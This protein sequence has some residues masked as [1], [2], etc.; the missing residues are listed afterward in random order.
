MR[1]N[2]DKQELIFYYQNED[3]PSEMISKD[4]LIHK[5]WIFNEETEEPLIC[6]GKKI[7]LSP[8]FILE[9]EL[10]PKAKIGFKK[11]P[12][13]SKPAG[14]HQIQKPKE[15]WRKNEP[16][17]NTGFFDDFKGK[18]D[19]KQVEKFKRNLEVSFAKENSISIEQSVF[20]DHLNKPGESKQHKPQVFKVVDSNNPSTS[21]GQSISVDSFFE[22]AD[23]IMGSSESEVKKT[24]NNKITQLMS[25]DPN[26]KV[27]S[28]DLIFKVND[29]LQYP[30][31]EK[32]WYIYHTGA[33]SSFGP[34]SSSNIKELYE[35]KMLDGMSEVRFIDIYNLKNKK[36]F[37]FFHLKELEHYQFLENIEISGLLKIAVNIK[38]RILNTSNKNEKSPFDIN[39]LT[40]EPANI[41]SIVTNNKRENT[42]SGD[43]NNNK[44]LQIQPNASKE[45]TP[46]VHKDLPKNSPSLDDDSIYNIPLPATSSKPQIDENI[47][48]IKKVEDS[49]KSSKSDNKKNKKIPVP[50]GKPVELEVKLGMIQFI[51]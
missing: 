35:S 16:E 17:E 32:L 19:D 11:G 26:P 38:S 47:V 49:P 46:S 25:F 33:K 14:K 36:P 40:S 42:K 6:Q 29:Y 5:E 39:K 12:Q 13:P 50:K 8:S 24:K 51:L 23:L 4:V 37:E 30:R 21:I 22:N 15:V 18:T 2:Y 27:V 3:F 10:E 44:S 31:D 41:N 43:I 20:S 9:E 34:L 48:I 28:I 1:R 7:K 45:N